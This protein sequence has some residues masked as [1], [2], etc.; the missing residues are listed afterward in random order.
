[1]LI[2]LFKNIK[3][4]VSTK[5]VFYLCC[6]LVICVATVFIGAVPTHKFGHDTFFLLDNSWRV[7]NGQRTHI[8]YSSAWGPL[9][10]LIISLG[11]KISQYT[12]NGIGYGNAIFGFLIG[13]W[14]YRLGRYRLQYPFMLL[15]SLFMTG[16]VVSPYALGY[17]VLNS[18]HAMVYNR[19]GY[20]L[21]GLILLE[22]MQPFHHPRE[23]RED[24]AGG[25][26]TGAAMAL[27]LFLKVSY[28][29]ASIPLV[30]G[31]LIIS[32]HIDRRRIFGIMAGFSLVATAF[33]AYL[34]FDIQA[35]FHDL[36]M[37][38]GAR[39]ESLTY[40]Y[41]MVKLTWNAIYLAAIILF[42]FACSPAVASSQKQWKNYQLSLA[43]VLVFATDIF[44]LFTNQQW[45]ELPLIATF[46][47]IICN[48]INTHHIMIHNKVLLSTKR[49]Y[50][51]LMMVGGAIFLPIFALQYIAL[52]HAT[53][54]KANPPNVQTIARFTQPCLNDLLLYEG[55]TLSSNGRQY[56][57]YV[58]DGVALLLSVANKNETVLTIDMF[59]PFPFALGWRPPSGGIAAAAYKYTISESHRPSDA[60]YFG[61]AD[62]VMVPIK[63]AADNSYYYGVLKIYEP[64]LKE[65]YFLAAKSDWWYLFR[66][67]K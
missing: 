46:I 48:N 23:R 17:G 37:A 27:T 8:D 21:L 20:A 19:Y 55:E 36:Q 51:L 3:L 62:I 5:D 52:A 67:K 9:T 22:S 12:V 61:N 43:G 42:S 11:L 63:P 6:L 60:K 59:N 44:L 50:A 33:F 15:F 57:S 40:H 54:E 7:V 18:T 13:L 39:S 16:L 53:L 56:T 65:R 4:C 66:R 30:F 1:M 58:N 47:L 49:T 45:F 25:I 10:F 31:I 26:S 35:V 28:F 2:D 64:A 14:A 38:A 34:S 24:W 41:M 29:L 32:M